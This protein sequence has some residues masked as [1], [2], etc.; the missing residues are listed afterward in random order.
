MVVQGIEQTPWWRRWKG[1]AIAGV[2]GIAVAVA[3][4]TI[5]L[6]PAASSAQEGTPTATPTQTPSPTATPTPL[7]QLTE[8]VVSTETQ[9]TTL[10]GRVDQLSQLHVQPGIITWDC[11]ILQS[12]QA[13]SYDGKV[14]ESEIHNHVQNLNLMLGSYPLSDI[15]IQAIA[16]DCSLTLN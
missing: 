15:G 12:V 6:W 5:A 8:R 3:V 9:L 4:A 7:D 14:S 2:A 10:T 13:R 1:V 11:S 16:T